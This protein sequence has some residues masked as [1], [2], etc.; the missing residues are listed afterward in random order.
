MAAS[1]TRLQKHSVSIAGHRTSV[2]LEAAFWE[3]LTV[4]AQ[5]RNAT[6]AGLIAEIDDARAADPAAPNLSSAIRVFVLRQRD[7]R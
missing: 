4:I 2:T 3:A 6:V 5:R 7:A 1:P